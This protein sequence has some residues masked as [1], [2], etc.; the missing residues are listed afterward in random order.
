MPSPYDSMGV[1]ESTMT[2]SSAPTDP[3]AMEITAHISTPSVPSSSHPSAMN[4]TAVTEEHQPHDDDDV[5]MDTTANNNSS[6]SPTQPTISNVND[7]DVQ[8]APR[9]DE[10]ENPIENSTSAMMN[11]LESSSSAPPEQESATHGASN[12]PHNDDDERKDPEMVSLDDSMEE[13]YLLTDEEMNNNSV[14]LLDAP[15]SSSS[16]PS[17]EQNNRLDESLDKLQHSISVAIL[18]FRKEEQAKESGGT[19]NDGSAYVK[20]R[21]AA[22]EAYQTLVE[23][24]SSLDLNLTSNIAPMNKRRREKLEKIGR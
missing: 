2:S 10:V 22:L 4:N 19:S 23:Y 14:K 13:Q 17:A 1:G 12:T 15:P 8:M 6:A 5:A 18:A 11:D 9:E 20:L 24:G 7:A 21:E 3:S 16:L